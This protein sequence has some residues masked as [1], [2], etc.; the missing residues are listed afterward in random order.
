[1]D[2]LLTQHKVTINET[3]PQIEFKK[4]FNWTLISIFTLS[5]TKNHVYLFIYPLEYL[6]GPCVSYN[7]TVWFM[8]GFVFKQNCQSKHM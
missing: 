1:M 7:K 5:K 4:F 3:F 8:F 6:K 2:P